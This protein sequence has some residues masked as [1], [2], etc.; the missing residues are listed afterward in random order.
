MSLLVVTFNSILSMD[1]PESSSYTVIKKLN[2]REMIKKT[3]LQLLITINKKHSKDVNSEFI[4]FSKI[5]M[6]IENFRA[7]R[8]M[9]QNVTEPNMLDD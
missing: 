7:L 1:S 5:K 9:Y 4:R 8:R 3:A 2:I 6:L